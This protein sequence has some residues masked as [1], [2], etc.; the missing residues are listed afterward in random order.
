MP[1]K[2]LE[3]D[4]NPDVLKWARQSMGA[5]PEDIARRLG[6]SADA[7][8]EWETGANKPT[9]RTLEKLATYLKRPLA[10][11]FLPGPPDEL[12]MPQDFR[13]LPDA[14]RRPLSMK[15]RLA[16]RRA[17]RLQAI[18][19]ELMDAMGIKEA[20]RIPQADLRQQAETLAE[21]ERK[22]LG[23][24]VQA[25]F[26][27]KDA[28]VAFTNWRKGIEGQN[29][30]VFQLSMPVEEVRG[31]SLVDEGMPAVIVNSRDI[32]QA[33]IFSLF[34]EYAHIMLKVSGMCTP[35][36]VMHHGGRVEVFCNRFAGAF[37]VPKEALLQDN[38]MK[39]YVPQ[40]R[41]DEQLVKQVASRFKVSRHVILRRMELS[42]LITHTQYQHKTREWAR[43][44]RP[45]GRP[46]FRGASA[47]KRCMREK[48]KFFISLVL[49]ARD[50]E[51]VTQSNVLDYLSLRTKNIAQIEPLLR[52]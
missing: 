44:E 4:I 19:T 21:K 32:I 43:E 2:T 18:A 39:S 33:R 42:G 7:V 15:T 14:K 8:N 9:I 11:F 1:Q 13:V 45:M 41:I 29:I 27:W 48:G 49:E 26:E 47:A 31:L 52:K 38:D 10:A 12:P 50:R 46:H 36:E 6:T 20:L 23:I 30:L 24:S 16:I 28:Y 34:H 3:V 5:S 40:P 22:R 35:L 17:R 51:I 37:L 25:Q